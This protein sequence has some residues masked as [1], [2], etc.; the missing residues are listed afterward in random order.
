[1]CATWASDRPWGPV[2]TD[3]RCLSR[4]VAVHSTTSCTRG[5]ADVHVQTPERLLFI[6]PAFPSPGASGS[7]PC[8]RGMRA[9]G[10]LCPP[11]VLSLFRLCGKE[12]SLPVLPAPTPCSPQVY[13]RHLYTGVRTTDPEEIVTYDS[14]RIPIRVKFTLTYEIQD[15]SKASQYVW[16]LTLPLCRPH[17]HTATTYSHIHTQPPPP[18][19]PFPNSTHNQVTPTSLPS[20]TS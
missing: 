6:P 16:W 2:G 10:A 1:M 12:G 14:Q 17:S 15:A 8:A 9:V 13:E 3:W 19:T 7:S 5:C 20:D 18:L 11:A 4:C